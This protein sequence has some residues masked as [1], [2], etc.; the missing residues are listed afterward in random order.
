MNTRR[1]RRHRQRT[2][3]IHRTTQRGGNIDDL[4]HAA[5]RGDLDQVKMLVETGI[6]FAHCLWQFYNQSRTDQP[7]AIWYLGTLDNYEKHRNNSM[8]SLR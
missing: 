7:H 4:V 3:R 1:N 6:G 8:L 5:K 2:L